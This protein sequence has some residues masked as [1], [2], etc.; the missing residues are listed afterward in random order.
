MSSTC[1]KWQVAHHTGNCDELELWN[2]GLATACT[3]WGWQ[4]SVAIHWQK[5]QSINRNC[6][7]FFPKS[8]KGHNLKSQAHVCDWEF[9]VFLISW[10]ISTLQGSHAV[11]IVKATLSYDT[12]KCNTFLSWGFNLLAHYMTSVVCK[13][14]D[15]ST[16][17]LNMHKTIWNCKAFFSHECIM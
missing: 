1:S 16:Q 8:D 4:R 3:F 6:C 13:R 15:G 17:D 14:R 5:N 10:Q 9:K 7:F 12:H 2:A 11:R